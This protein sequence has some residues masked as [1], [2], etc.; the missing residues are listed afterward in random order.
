MPKFYINI[1]T[2]WRANRLTF[3][4]GSPNTNRGL[5]INSAFKMELSYTDCMVKFI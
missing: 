1:L 4:N 5:C 2:Q 3:G